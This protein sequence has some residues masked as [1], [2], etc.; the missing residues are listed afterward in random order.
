MKK[1]K[2]LLINIFL[3]YIM[4]FISG[5]ASLQEGFSSQME[6]PTLEKQVNRVAIGMTVV[7]QN[8]LMIND[9]PISADAQWPQAI[10]S[11]LEDTQKQHIADILQKDP[12]YATAHY[13]DPIQR[14]M[15]GSSAIMSQFGNYGHF[16][17]MLLNQTISPITYRAIQKTEAFYGKNYKNWPKIFNYGKPLDNFLEF[18]GGKRVIVEAI[19]GDV[20]QNLNEALISLAPIGMQKDLKLTQADM[21]DR[22]EELSSLKLQK[23]QKESRLKLDA[24]QVKTKDKKED[25]IFLKNREKLEIQQDLLILEEKI[26]EA[27]SIADEHEKI[28]FA[29]LDNAIAEIQN[30]INLEDMS[31]VKLAK[32]INI[33]SKEIRIGAMQAYTSFALALTNI[34]SNDII[35]K[36]PK[37]LVSLAMGKMYIPSNLQRKYDK[38]ILRVIENSFYLLPNILMGTYYATKQ[39]NLAKKYQDIAEVIVI[40]YEAKNDN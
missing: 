10:S 4:I 15:L 22:Y 7:R 16:T 33:V 24:A 30:E 37:E 20:Y 28:Y 2:L 31:Y 34:A 17:A 39:I 36:F 27:E 8:N 3:A 5:C 32:N 19:S 35:M 21:S 18:K 29:L 38:R 14:K 1:I 12:Y 13:T 40:A 25:Y 6:V 9:M 26:N 11:E 23:A